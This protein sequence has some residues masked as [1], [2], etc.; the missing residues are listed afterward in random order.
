MS[1]KVLRD[2]YGRRVEMT[3][4]PGEGRVYFR[5]YKPSGAQAFVLHFDLG[6]DEE[7]ALISI[8]KM[9]DDELAADA[10]TKDLVE[11]PTVPT[12][13]L[14]KRLFSRYRKQRSDPSG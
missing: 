4:V 2:R 10:A 7:Q 3:E 14:R 1:E 11:V 9:L 13:L 8:E 6:W 12:L 5:V